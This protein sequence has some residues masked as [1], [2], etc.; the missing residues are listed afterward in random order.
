MSFGST[1]DVIYGFGYKRS[2]ESSLL[3]IDAP[4]F[5]SINQPN[6]VGFKYAP[7]NLKTEF[8]QALQPF[9]TSI[10]TSV[11]NA[12]VNQALANYWNK[13]IIGD[14]INTSI[15]Q[16]LANYWDK[17][18]ISDAID[19]AID[20]A[21]F[22]TTYPGKSVCPKTLSF[23]DPTTNVTTYYEPNVVVRADLRVMQ[24]DSQY[25][26]VKS[27]GLDFVDPFTSTVGSMAFKLNGNTVFEI[28]QGETTGNVAGYYLAPLFKTLPVESVSE[29]LKSVVP[30][31]NPFGEAY[32]NAWIGSFSGD[33]L[34]GIATGN[35]IQ[36]I[37]RGL[38]RSPLASTSSPSTVSIG[39][40][41][42]SSPVQNTQGSRTPFWDKYGYM[43][44]NKDGVMTTQ[45]NGNLMHQIPMPMSCLYDIIDYVEY[46]F[47]A[48]K[49]IDAINNLL[50]SFVLQPLASKLAKK[51]MR[52]LL[53]GQIGSS[54]SS[55]RRRGGA[56]WGLLGTIGG[57]IAGALTDLFDLPD[58]PDGYDPLPDG[59][60]GSNDQEPNE[61]PWMTRDV[62]IH[63]KPQWVRV[64]IN[65]SKP[66]PAFE[67]RDPFTKGY[68]ATFRDF[69]DVMKFPQALPPGAD[70]L[71]TPP[72]FEERVV[73]NRRGAGIKLASGDDDGQSDKVGYLHLRPVTGDLHLIAMHGKQ[74]FF[75]ND[76]TK[77]WEFTHT[78]DNPIFT[79]SNTGVVEAKV[80]TDSPQTM[81]LTNAGPALGQNPDSYAGLK[82]QFTYPVL[83]TTDSKTAFIR[84]DKQGN[85]M[86]TLDNGSCF[87]LN[88]TNGNG[89]TFS[90]PVD[91]GKYELSSGGYMSIT[92]EL[93]N[94]E[95]QLSLKCTNMRATTGIKL[96]NSSSSYESFIGLR[97]DGEVVM[98]SPTSMRFGTGVDALA[99][100]RKFTFVMK[101]ATHNSKDIIYPNIV[102]PENVW[103]NAIIDNGCLKL[104]NNK[105]SENLSGTFNKTGIELT[106]KYIWLYAERSYTSKMYLDS[107]GQLTMT[108]A[109]LKVNFKN[110]DN[111]NFDTYVTR[112]VDNE[113]V[114]PNTVFRVSGTIVTPPA[115]TPIPTMTVG[116]QRVCI[117]NLYT[118]GDYKLDV[119]GKVRFNSGLDLT[120]GTVNFNNGTIINF[121]DGATVNFNGNTR[122]N[123]QTLLDIQYW[124]LRD[125]SKH[126]YYM[127]NPVADGRVGIGTDVPDTPLHVI[128]D[129]THGS[130]KFINA[131]DSY[132]MQRGAQIIANNYTEFYNPPTALNPVP[133]NYENFSQ[134]TVNYYSY[135]IYTPRMQFQFQNGTDPRLTLE[136]RPNKAYVYGEFRCDGDISGVNILADN[137]M[138][139][140]NLYVAQE[141][142]CDTLWA[143][144]SVRTPT[145]YI[146]QQYN[147][148][149]YL[150][151]SDIRFKNVKGKITKVL[152]KLD[153]LSA[154]EYTLKDSKTH[155]DQ[156]HIGCI[157]QEVQ[158]VFPQ[159]VNEHE[160]RLFMNYV[161]MIPI[162]IQA[163]KELRDLLVFKV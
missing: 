38:L 53:G 107:M 14:I 43:A 5:S 66:Q 157:A 7:R 110:T 159:L 109:G 62:V 131:N 140:K 78:K 119:N 55:R 9:I 30:I 134:P 13:T 152:D 10:S 105:Y 149:S 24:N 11:S 45:T 47:E 12:V 69:D 89:W 113:A 117:N 23:K 34:V 67:V 54:S 33:Y 57:G 101:E 1:H 84:M 156:V 15:N 102:I 91:K 36:A 22:W 74:S 95:Y 37:P 155:N 35:I 148:G 42:F 86:H 21:T 137:F 17:T 27:S 123:N 93:Q 40:T 6:G 104:C 29:D 114:N 25:L 108:Q 85:M 79:I 158:E 142:R 153:K 65:T 97:P 90:N 115:N 31:S 145:A 46:R 96:Q 151:G 92:N 16:A 100:S 61:L 103:D 98:T 3:P 82:F 18:T 51:V 112:D 129:V 135:K 58:I 130:I 71:T 88:N 99:D 4:D 163:I 87:F 32:W 141:A 80:T 81:T 116:T 76:A 138:S 139:C 41:V 63:N 132:F 127:T 60:D 106:A 125:N 2:L 64:G 50:M 20:K 19:T 162:L 26:S 48:Q 118:D 161:G 124:K 122:F 73:T 126:I 121:N 70:P 128:G 28:I 143:V 75:V 94:S 150:L 44:L 49:D 39:T 77:G 147:F 144:R 83:D 120:G 154:Y 8:E 72:Q 146:D 52:F 59:D 136:L 56:G 111:C 133:S 68:Q 160:D